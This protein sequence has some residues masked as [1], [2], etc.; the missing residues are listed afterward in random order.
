MKAASAQ[1]PA[2]NLA[3]HWRLLHPEN[4]ANG[5][6]EKIEGRE[7]RVPLAWR[8]VLKVIADAFVA[9][10]VPTGN[11]I[12]HVDAQVAVVNF[13]NIRSYPDA[14]GPLTEVS[15]ETSICAW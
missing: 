11:G 9:G 12:G 13:D 10:R 2:F 4:M 15:W 3:V 7:Q 5:E 8:P 6:A 1:C 14:I